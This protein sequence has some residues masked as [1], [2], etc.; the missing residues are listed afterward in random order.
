MSFALL[1]L[2]ASLVIAD[3]KPEVTESPVD[4]GERVPLYTV[5]P[6][7]PERAKRAR[8]EGEVQICFNVDRDGK[9]RRVAVRRSTNRVFEKPSRDAVR[10]STYKP[11]PKA[12]ELSGIKTCRTFRFYLMPVAIET[13]DN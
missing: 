6:Q 7:Y 3:D 4:T 9:T 11:L 13:P 12:M 10:E 1:L 8:V 5:V 2:V